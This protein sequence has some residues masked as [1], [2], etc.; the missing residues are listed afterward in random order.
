MADLKHYRVTAE[1]TISV[2]C[3]V[4]ARNEKHA[5]KLAKNATP[6]GMCHSC[7][8]ESDPEDPEW[9][10]DELDGEPKIVS[11]EESDDG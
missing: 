5:R 8:R 11:V 10:A 3:I 9:V 4:E 7:S 6:R 1:V 2:T